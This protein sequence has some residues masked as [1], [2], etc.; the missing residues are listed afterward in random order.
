M[1]AFKEK[2][3]NTHMDQDKDRQCWSDSIKY[4]KEIIRKLNDA[5]I[6]PKRPNELKLKTLE[7]LLAGVK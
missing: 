2:G 4:R 7:S 3:M 1:N 5:G 6:C